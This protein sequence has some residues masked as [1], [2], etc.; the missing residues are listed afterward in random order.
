MQY[1]QRRR[2]V[3]NINV[4]RFGE[5][6]NANGVIVD[7]SSFTST[8]AILGAKSWLLGAIKPKHPGGE[9]VISF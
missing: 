7:P 2:L 8:L 9:S 5:V 6:N 4:G 1:L 3:C